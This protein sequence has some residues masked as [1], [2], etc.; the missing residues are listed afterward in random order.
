MNRYLHPLQCLILVALMG[1]IPAS[2]A[3]AEGP[4]AAVPV[5]ADNW[6]LRR[7][8]QPSEGELLREARGEVVIYDGLTDN[9][10][11]SALSLHTRRIRSM[12]FVGT[13]LTDDE[14]APQMDDHGMF[15]QQDDGC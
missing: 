11:E 1:G 15:I 2:L 6:Q 7:L 9:Q 12:M 5:Y 14:G 13:I 10:V 3:L 4:G 8:M